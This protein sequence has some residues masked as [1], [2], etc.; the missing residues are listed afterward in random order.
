MDLRDLEVKCTTCGA[1]P[2]MKVRLNLIG[3]KAVG[4]SQIYWACPNEGDASH[5]PKV[6]FEY[7]VR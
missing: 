6:E 5:P 1:A 4:G 3:G 7:T 2:I